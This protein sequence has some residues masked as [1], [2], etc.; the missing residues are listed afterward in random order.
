MRYTFTESSVLR[1][2]ESH[3][4]DV[5]QSKKSS[6]ALVSRDF[7]GSSILN[8]QLDIVWSFPLNYMQTV[9]LGVAK[10]IWELWQSRIL[11]PSERTKIYNRIE[12]IQPAREVKRVPISLGS[13][14]KW[15]AT[16]WKA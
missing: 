14:S 16:D 5:E 15:K 13:K 4:I 10:Q 7:K 8:D 6:S 12:D 9:V 1:I 3:K 2:N 11:K